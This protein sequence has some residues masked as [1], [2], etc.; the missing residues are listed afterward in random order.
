[1]EEILIFLE[2]EKRKKESG[3]AVKSVI[4]DA[5]ST[6]TLRITVIY[7][8]IHTHTLS[9]TKKVLILIIDRLL[10]RP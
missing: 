8:V 3:G 9:H 7:D 10:R 6:V 2:K 5:H 4:V 1:M